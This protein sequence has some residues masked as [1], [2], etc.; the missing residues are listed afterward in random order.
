[1]ADLLYNSQQSSQA[2]NCSTEQTN[3]I[4]LLWWERSRGQCLRS[5]PPYHRWSPPSKPEVKPVCPINLTISSQLL[6]T[7][8][9]IVFESTLRLELLYTLLSTTLL[10][11]EITS[12]VVAHSSLLAKSLSYSY[13]SGSVDNGILLS[14]TPFP[15]NEYLVGVGGSAVVSGVLYLPLF[16]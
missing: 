9:S 11:A 14:N 10:W 16:H 5:G 12:C 13:E 3:Q 15:K 2:I 4:R 6:F 1:M 7:T 8:T